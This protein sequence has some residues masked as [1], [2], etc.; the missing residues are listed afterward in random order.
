MRRRIELD[1]QAVADFP[2]AHWPATQNVLGLAAVATDVDYYVIKS[3][4][5]TQA[6]AI[7][8][9]LMKQQSG[10]YLARVTVMGQESKQQELEANQLTPAMG[11]NFQKWTRLMK[12]N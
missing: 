3:L 9:S 2:A 10:R 8:S 4:T 7:P 12:R 11:I 5:S 1:I 6:Y